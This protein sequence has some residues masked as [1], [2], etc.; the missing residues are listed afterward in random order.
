MIFLR[1]IVYNERNNQK[2]LRQFLVLMNNQSENES[3]F[4]RQMWVVVAIVGVVGLVFL[5]QDHTSHIFS[6][7]PYLI[8]LACPLMHLLMHKPHGG[9]KGGV[10]RNHYKD[11]NQSEHNHV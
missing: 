4:S 8:L 11:I 2:D 10:G 1:S 6:L 9:H 7:V 3:L 5:L